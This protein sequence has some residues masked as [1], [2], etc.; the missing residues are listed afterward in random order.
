M[1]IMRAGAMLSV[2]MAWTISTAGA[3]DRE[4]KH[5][6]YFRMPKTG[7]TWM[8]RFFT[9]TGAKPCKT[10]GHD[11]RLWLHDHG[12]G[13]EKDPRSCNASMVDKDG[14]VLAVIREPVDHFASQYD[15]MRKNF[16]KLS[17]AIE[18]ERPF[19]EWLAKTF[20]GCG[21]P[22]CRVKRL[23]ESYSELHRVI[24]Y[25]QSLFVG[26]PDAAEIVC[27]AK[28]GEHM[29]DDVN[30]VLD[31]YILPKGTCHVPEPGPESERVNRDKNHPDGHSVGFT[32]AEICA[33]YPEDC[34][35]W[36]RMCASRPRS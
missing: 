27:Y 11:A 34:A 12:K 35:L 3:V 13:C 22:H 5:L 32:R 2:A 24:L 36:E 8:M 28:E 19:Y 31:K 25:P 17:Y 14:V 30:D 6:E 10:N 33:L 16:V 26:D 15:H 7:S 20:K 23:V 9:T 18:G 4:G 21:D 29:L 1:K